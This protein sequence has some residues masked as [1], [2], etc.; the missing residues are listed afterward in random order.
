[1]PKEI[2]E[3]VLEL[4]GINEDYLISQYPGILRAARLRDD[5]GESKIPSNPSENDPQDVYSVAKYI[6]N[7]ACRFPF[8]DEIEGINFEPFLKVAAAQ[9]FKGQQYYGNIRDSDYSRSVMF[10][11]AYASGSALSKFPY[12]DNITDEIYSIAM[13]TNGL[14]LESVP[15]NRMT[16]DI[17]EKAIQSNPSAFSYAR[18]DLMTESMIADAIDYNG[19]FIKYADGDKVT[20]EMAKKAILKAPWAIGYI[21]ERLMTEELIIEAAKR[22][23]MI[24]DEIPVGKLSNK[25]VE[26]AIKQ[27]PCA[28]IVIP[29]GFLHDSLVRL[30]GKSHPE[31]KDQDWFKDFCK[32]NGLSAKKTNGV[33]ISPNP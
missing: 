23:G 10:G 25:V 32:E 3:K 17:I 1:M 4:N 5:M 24:L 21:P 28:L 2:V 7:Q 27:T 22:D 26:S 15:Q 19:G 33:D 16:M 18:K 30:A 11:M 6:L 20:Q 29:S 9:F 12:P 14:Q 31:V 8:K 13:E